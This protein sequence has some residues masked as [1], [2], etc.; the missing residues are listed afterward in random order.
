MAKKRKKTNLTYVL[1]GCP[2]DIM[3][4]YDVT[5]Y[6]GKLA[7]GKVGLVSSREAAFIYRDDKDPGHGAPE[8]WVKLFREDY[9]LNVKPVFL[10]E[11]CD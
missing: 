10:C 8:D 11:A 4:R 3:T 6:V 1:H 7:D 9:G 2:V 5:G